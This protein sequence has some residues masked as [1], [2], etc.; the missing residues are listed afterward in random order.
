MRFLKK[1]LIGVYI[2]LAMFA[3]AVLFVFSL[4]GNEPTILI[5]A[6]FGVAGIESMLAALIKTMENGKK[7]RETRRNGDN[8][9]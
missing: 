8:N 5:G 2:Y 1:L 6:V 9:K 3:M 4:T 7:T